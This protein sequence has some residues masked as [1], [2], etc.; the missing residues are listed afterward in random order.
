MQ[1]VCLNAPW[2][3]L[4]ECMYI[5]EIWV[6]QWWTEQ[7]LLDLF[8]AATTGCARLSGSMYHMCRLCL[9]NV[10][11]ILAC[12]NVIILHRMIS[13]SPMDNRSD[14][15]STLHGEGGVGGGGGW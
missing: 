15:L 5:A 1:R 13:L 10:V 7:R 11:Y 3:I 14:S 9:S 4:F 8:C 12:N 2:C 6:V